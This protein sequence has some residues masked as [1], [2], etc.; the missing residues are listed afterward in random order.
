MD[1]RHFT[2][3]PRYYKVRKMALDRSK[4]EVRIKV[5]LYPKTARF[6][7]C[8]SF[9]CNQS[10]WDSPWS[11]DDISTK[12]KFNLISEISKETLDFVFLW[13][14]SNCDSTVSKKVKKISIISNVLPLHFAPCQESWNQNSN[15][16][17]KPHWRVIRSNLLSP[18]E[19]TQL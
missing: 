16:D 3:S 17:D 12:H 2:K 5:R 15:F 7:N 11:L 4:I 13:I 9:W 10:N 1:K 18:I 19:F 14:L 6:Q 8:A